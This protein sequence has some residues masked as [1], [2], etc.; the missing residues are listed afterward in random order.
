MQV[1]LGPDIGLAAMYGVE[2]AGLGHPLESLN[3]QVGQ[4]ADCWCGS[5]P[6]MPTPT[7]ALFGIEREH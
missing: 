1:R 5:L 2:A 4:G 7:T 3:H 6:C